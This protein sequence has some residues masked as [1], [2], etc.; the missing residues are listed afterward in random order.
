MALYRLFTENKNRAELEKLVS[1][2]FSGFT[3]YNA[4]GYWHKQKEKSLIIE[5][6]ADDVDA[7]ITTLA[8]AIKVIN[9]QEAVLIQ[10]IQN[11]QW[12]V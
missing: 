4:T 12:L 3:L 5:I 11:N 8:E 9:K 6:V 7:N 1:E 2:H 10:T